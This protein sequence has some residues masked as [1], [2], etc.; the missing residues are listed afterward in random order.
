MLFRSDAQHQGEWLGITLKGHRGKPD[1]QGAMV[2]MTA[3]DW[4]HRQCVTPVR[5]YLS[6]CDPRVLV[7][8]PKGCKVVDI[9][10]T[11]PDGSKTTKSV[12]TLSAYITLSQP[13]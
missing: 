10:V 6:M 7:S 4:S 1:M 12:S 8:L 5:S 2:T 9:D 13:S 11:W 3:G